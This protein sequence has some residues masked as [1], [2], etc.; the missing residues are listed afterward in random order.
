MDKLRF[1]TL[2]AG[3]FFAMFLGGKWLLTPVVVPLQP[4]P[5]LPTFQ[6]VDP[7]DPR[8]K[9]EQS[10]VSDDDPVRDHLRNEVL[11]YAKALG[12]D[13]CNEVLKRNYI[14]A[15]V[16]YARAWIAIVPCIGTQ[17][18]RNADSQL[19][20]RAAHAFGSPL[21]HRVRDAMR[22]AHQKALF[23]S[24]D[25]PKDTVHLVADLAADSSINGPHETREFRRIS[26][27]L[28]DAS[29]RRDCG[30]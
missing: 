4:D 10:S 15:V 30:H 19:L 12:D 21:D 6:R 3:L 2:V 24:A 7:D 20:D 9:L 13:P 17:T 8:T 14:K 5:R 1:G 28:D 26:A 11:D 27:Q 23:G 22:A 29:T 18:C 16:A 25:F